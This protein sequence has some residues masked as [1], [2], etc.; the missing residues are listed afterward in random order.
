MQNGTIQELCSFGEID[1]SKFLKRHKDGQA[2]P[3]HRKAGMHSSS[4]SPSLK[5]AGIKTPSLQKNKTTSRENRYHVIDSYISSEALGIKIDDVPLDSIVEGTGDN[6]K[7]VAYQQGSTF[8]EKGI[9]HI[10]PNMKT[11]RIHVPTVRDEEFPEFRAMNDELA[12]ALVKNYLKP[13]AKFEL[14]QV[15]TVSRRVPT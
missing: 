6:Y 12:R 4:A 15:S 2:F 9:K 10:A 14:Y 8:S 3:T 5:S 1:M 11:Y 13:N 7:I